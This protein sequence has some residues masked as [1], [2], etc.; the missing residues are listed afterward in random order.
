MKVVELALDP[1]GAVVIE[2]HESATPRDVVRIIGPPLRF[3]P[4]D[5]GLQLAEPRIHV[6][7]QFLGRLM[8]FGHWSNSVCIVVR[9]A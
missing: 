4:L 6:I 7:S 2:D 1:N 9:T 8:L 5:F 3:Q